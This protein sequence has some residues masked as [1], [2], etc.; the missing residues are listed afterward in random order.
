MTRR[1]SGTIVDPAQRSFFDPPQVSLIGFSV[2]LREALSDTFA[3]AKLRLG[4]GRHDVAAE[5]SRIDP[6]RDVSADMLYNY[7]SQSAVKHRLPAD[8]VPAICRVTQDN[9]L[10][11]LIAEAA[12]HKVVPGEAAVIAELV[13]L[14]MDE[15]SIRE[16]KR[17]MAKRV[18]P[19]VVRWAKQEAARKVGR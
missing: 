2:T 16:R 15:R 1:R 14:E 12:D 6:S 7:S 9:R 19:D 8:L 13:M 17:A 18:G 10:L 4:M 11:S 5:I 3:S